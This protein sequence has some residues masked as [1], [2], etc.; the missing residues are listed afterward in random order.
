MSH[1]NF[2]RCNFCNARG[3]HFVYNSC[4]FYGCMPT[5]S[6]SPQQPLTE[7]AEVTETRSV[8]VTR[9]VGTRSKMELLVMNHPDPAAF[10]AQLKLDVAACD[11]IKDK[12]RVVNKAIKDGYLPVDLPHP[13]FFEEI[14]PIPQPS[15]SK[16]INKGNIE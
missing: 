7:T 6:Q 12:M 13:T 5:E 3:A 15:F 11:K 16:W 8:K 1:K 14:D 10:I 4:N 9:P 2:N